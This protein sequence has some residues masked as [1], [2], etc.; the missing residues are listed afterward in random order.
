MSS[1]GNLPKEIQRE[2]RKH[3]DIDTATK[4]SHTSRGEREHF[5][6]ERQTDI[7]KQR[8]RHEIHTKRREKKFGDMMNY[9]LYQNGVN[10]LWTLVQI[11]AYKKLKELFDDFEAI[12]ASKTYQLDKR[13]MG[14]LYDEYHMDS[15]KPRA[16][17]VIYE[18]F[19]AAGFQNYQKKQL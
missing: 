17:D 7:R 9:M 2:V 16:F 10:G 13:I 14:A 4:L 3:L 5:Y 11:D 12:E 19:R 18:M 15:Y 1:Y 6:D 8:E